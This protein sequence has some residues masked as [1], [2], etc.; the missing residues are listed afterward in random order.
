MRTSD[1]IKILNYVFNNYSNINIEGTIKSGFQTFEK[2]FKNNTTIKK[3]MYEPVLKLEQYSNT[4]FPLLKNEISHLEIETYSLNNLSA[5]IDKDTKVGFL[6]IKVNDEILK[7]VD[8]LVKNKIE[9]KNFKIYYQ[10]LLKNIF[11]FF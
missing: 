3:A 9:K 4:T 2:H 11:N 5:P 6:T 10:E 8:I 7:K 1:S